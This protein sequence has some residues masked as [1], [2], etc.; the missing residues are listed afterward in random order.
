MK[1]LKMLI[2]CA[3]FWV[4]GLI[5]LNRYWVVEASFPEITIYQKAE[6]CLPSKQ[7]V[8]DIKYIASLKD[9]SATYYSFYVTQKIP[10]YFVD[11]IEEVIRR[12]VVRVD[13]MGC[14]VIMPV[15]KF[16]DSMTLYMPEQVAFE[17]L[18]GEIEQEIAQSGGIQDFI[19]KFEQKGSMD[20][21]GD[22]GAYVLPEF[23][24]VY[25]KLGIPLPRKYTVIDSFTKVPEYIPIN[26]SMS[27][28]DFPD[29]SIFRNKSGK[30]SK[31]W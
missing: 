11:N 27:P 31:K 5:L 29:N 8:Q 9:G 17:L 16:E 26:P 23:V 7:S 25:K 20:E 1:T 15:E 21:M 14:L 13:D 22:S 30:P 28:D 24:Y 2:G 3:C 6:T 12:T 19:R 4:A 18:Q 10:M